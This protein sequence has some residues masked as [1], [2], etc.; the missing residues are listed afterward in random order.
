MP[1]RRIEELIKNF[2]RLD[3]RQQLIALNYIK[4]RA[5]EK[6]QQPLLR[7]VGGA[8]QVRHVRVTD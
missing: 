8:A 2:C 5:E 6:P 1:D 4:D 3:E 7:V